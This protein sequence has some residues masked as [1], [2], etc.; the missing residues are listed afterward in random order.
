[1][2]KFAPPYLLLFITLTITQAA[3]AADGKPLEGKKL[4][5]FVKTADPTEA[6]MGLSLA[7]SAVT[8][9]AKVTVVLG[10]NAAFYPVKKYGQNV[11]AAKGQTHR[12]M[13]KTIIADGGQV[14]LCGLCAKHHGLKTEDLIDGVK[15]VKSIKIFEALYEEN[16]RS[17]SF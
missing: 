2:R 12:D 6:G 4:V 17:M 8:K 10:A 13:L 7:H 11:F 3:F 1:M 15:I 14:Y 16:A 5:V 9:G